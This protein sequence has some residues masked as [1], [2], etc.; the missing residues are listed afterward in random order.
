MRVF[1]FGGGITRNGMGF[2]SLFEVELSMS[3]IWTDDIHLGTDV[4]H[5]IWPALCIIA[6]MFYGRTHGS[7]SW[8]PPLSFLS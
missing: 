7:C 2:V 6:C 1:F 5:S 8:E 4:Q 3:L